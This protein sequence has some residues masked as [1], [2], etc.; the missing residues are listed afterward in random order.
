MD[1]E[2]VAALVTASASLIV[3]VIAFLGSRNS[4][5]FSAEVQ[6]GLET[7][8]HR[9]T[10]L[11]SQAESLEKEFN[12]S[13]EGLRRGIQAIQGM[14]DQIYLLLGARP[15]DLPR[16]AFV[17]RLV[18]HRD[19]LMGSYEEWGSVLSDSEERALHLAKNAAICLCELVV[20]S[21]FHKGSHEAVSA[22]LTNNLLAIKSKLNDIQQQLRD[23]RSDRLEAR[24]RL[25]SRL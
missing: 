10:L 25:V 15:G 5:R 7:Q 4:A 13:L 11:A 19:Q 3:S 9:A 17:A 21:D 20:M 23:S 24:I 16:D 22:G 12:A 14:K 8:K 2:V 1:K 6:R 18:E